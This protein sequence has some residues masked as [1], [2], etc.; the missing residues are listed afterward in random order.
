MK[1]KYFRLAA[2][3]CVSLAVFSCGKKEK[4]PQAIGSEYLRPATMQYSKQ[5]TAEINTI[6]EKYVG[7][8][9]SRNF[10]EAADMLYTVRNDSVIPYD[11]KMKK[12]FC[13]AYRQFPIYAA[14][15]TSMVLRSDKNNQVDI[16]LQI[17][18]DGDISANKGTTTMSL[19][20][21]VKDG[22]WYLTLL[23]KNA[24][25]VIDVYDKDVNSY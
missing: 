11:D 8:V 3:L 18:Q 21:V 2:V 7:L 14:K 6:V 15:I 10:E 5:D 4:K 23:S 13:A 19:N 17:T 12:G 1:L 25:G 24:E 22:K 16:C 9:S 20:P